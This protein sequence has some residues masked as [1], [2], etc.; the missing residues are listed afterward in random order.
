MSGLVVVLSLFL[1]QSLF[2]QEGAKVEIPKKPS[3]QSF[4]FDYAEMLSPEE[5]SDIR[6]KADAIKKKNG[7]EV[8]VVTI[9]SLGDWTIEEFAHELFN[10]WGLGK[11]K[12]NNGLLLLVNKESIVANK[13]GR[14]RIEVGYG[15][16]GV[17]PDGKCGRILD[18]YALPAWEKQEYSKGIVDTVDAICKIV[19]GEEVELVQEAEEA[20][21][22]EMVLMT[23]FGLFLFGMVVFGRGKSGGGGHSRGYRGGSRSFGGGGSF[24]GGRSGGGGASR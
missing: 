21:T 1:I 9:N 2:S 4:V 24:G 10:T 16:E 13:S 19:E 15:L 6:T 22:I 14:V 8:T 18:T 23:I 5:I 7:A 3:E 20:N 17:L 11:E 12:A